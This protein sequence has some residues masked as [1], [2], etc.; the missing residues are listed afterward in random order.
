[1]YIF[2][3]VRGKL[4]ITYGNPEMGLRGDRNALAKETDQT[5][6]H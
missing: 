5:G 3:E 2:V 1:M 4:K 6:V